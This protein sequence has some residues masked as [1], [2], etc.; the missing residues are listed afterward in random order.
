MRRTVFAALSLMLLA[1]TPLLAQTGSDRLKKTVEE[2]VEIQKQTQQQQDQWEKDRAA[3]V[4]RYRAARSNV[5][6][7]LERKAV[8]Q[9]RLAAMEQSIAEMNRRLEEFAED[10][11]ALFADVEPPAEAVP[12]LI[13]PD[14][15][16]PNNLGHRFIGNAIA[17]AMLTAPGLESLWIYDHDYRSVGNYGKQTT[18]YA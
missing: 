1:G 5:D 7:L 13:H 12:R 17:N 8:E 2:T 6:F 14:G 16:H 18:R 15:V 3:L 4:A 9:K 10:Q 11:K